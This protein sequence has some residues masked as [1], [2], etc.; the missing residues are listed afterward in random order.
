MMEEF[1]FSNSEFDLMATGAGGS[2]TSDPPTT[3]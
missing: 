3:S 2:A 1:G